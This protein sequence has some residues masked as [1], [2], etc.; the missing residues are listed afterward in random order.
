MPF[1]TPMIWRE[2]MHHSTDCYFCQTV[3]R[4]FSSKNK[5]KIIYPDCRSAD[6]PLLHN[7]ELPVPTS[8]N[9]IVL[10]DEDDNGETSNE[11][12]LNDSD[13][14]PGGC[15]KAFVEPKLFSKSDVNDLVRDLDLSKQNSKVLASRMQERRCLLKSAKVT[16]F[17]KRNELLSTFFDKENGIMFLQRY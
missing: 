12:E 3:V 14:E 4:G 15:A 9:K 17:R 10:E 1:G 11:S 6:E 7:S 5:N 16:S 2:P 13:F 8:P